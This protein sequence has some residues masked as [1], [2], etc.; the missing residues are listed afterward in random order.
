M[1]AHRLSEAERQHGLAAP[2]LLPILARLGELRFEEAEFAEATVLRRRAMKIAIA[3]YGPGSAPAAETMAALADLYIDRRRYL[4]AEPLAIITTLILRDRLGLTDKTL[5]PVLV[6]RARI[7]LAQG[8]YASAVSWAKQAI[9]IDVKKGKP[10]TRALR[11][12]GAAFV[13]QQKF[14]EGELVLRQAVERDRARGNRLELARSLAALAKALVRHNH[15]AEA[16]PLIE[17]AGAIDQAC[18]GATHPLIAEDFDTLGLVYLGVDRPA[19]A[20]KAFRTGR[21][22]LERG[23]GRD[24]PALGYIMLDLARAEQVLGNK[25]KAQS[26]FTAAHRILNSAEEDE[27][28]RQTH[29]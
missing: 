21:D 19:D 22:L 29:V 6:D 24:S 11:V 8:D 5:A 17:E 20:V 25:D 12:L 15:F 16:L 23:A 13:A 14:A 10:Q 4:D 1:L 2:E 3:V 27:R 18:L 7:A 28:H 9:A 26:L